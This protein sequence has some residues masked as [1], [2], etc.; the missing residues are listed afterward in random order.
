MTKCTVTLHPRGLDPFQSSKA[1][2]L[3]KKSKLPWKDVRKQVR[4]VNGQLPGQ[5]A[6]ENAARTVAAHKRGLPSLNYANCGRNSVLTQEQQRGIV[7]FVKKWR[8]KRFCTGRYILSELKLKCGKRTVLRTLNAA[9][10][11][12]RAVPR[13]S[14]F[15]KDQLKNREA[16]VKA[17]GGKTSKW[18]AD[19]IGLVLD[20]VTLTCAPKPLSDREKHAAQA[21]KAMWL[22]TG[23]AL[24]NDLHTY[25]RYGV[26]LGR[27]VPLWGG[28]TGQGNFTF[29]LWSVN[30]KLD[31]DIW[32]RHIGDAV[33]QAASGRNIWHD[34]EKFL[35]QPKVYAKHGLTMRCFPPASGDLNPIEN[36]WAKVRAELSSR[37][38]ADIQARRTLTR[39]QFRQRVAQILHGLSVPKPGE[40]LNYFQKLVAGMPRRL[41]K[42]KA[43]GFGNCG[44]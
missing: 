2:F 16:F 39:A 7:A 12:W 4:T 17:Y 25:N 43:N 41:A 40:K 8:S 34:N 20:G 38:M 35:K 22:R 32:A 9:G 44:K 19:N 31:M 5:R 3:R 29:R 10:F 36:V 42:C 14:K 18:W 15:T 28:F 6:L 37:E 11:F 24:S 33:K 21:I 23:E 26:Q 13:K 27:K 1:W 30:P